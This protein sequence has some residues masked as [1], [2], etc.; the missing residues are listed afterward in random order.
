ML[1]LNVQ[2]DLQ[3]FKGKQQGAKDAAQMQL[4]QD[5]LKSSNY[6]IP[7]D[8]LELMRSSLRFSEIGSGLLIW[9]TPYARR[10]YY[11]PQYNFSKDVNPNARGMWFEEAKA[12]DKADWITNIQAEYAKFFNGK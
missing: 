8:T 7:S 5:I 11:N 3:S 12:M 2:M 9:N 1:K 4:D 6:F 10:L